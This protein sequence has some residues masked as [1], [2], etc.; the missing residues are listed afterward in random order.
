[1]LRRLLNLGSAVSLVLC[2]AVCVLWAVQASG[3]FW[4][5]RYAPADGRVFGVMAGR[6]AGPGEASCLRL[7]SV[8]PLPHPCLT[9]AF[10]GRGRS[11][12][13]LIM[14]NS[15]YGRWSDTVAVDLYDSEVEMVAVSPAGG[16]R[17]IA[18][19]GTARVWGVSLPYW[20]A[21]VAF[22]LPAVP[23]AGSAWRRHRGRRRRARIGLCPSCG[24]DLRATPG[25]CPECG[26]VAAGAV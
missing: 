9:T 19:L 15:P 25:R 12:T 21:V 7:T 1:M 3:H 5:L 8:S 22:G 4:L 6:R 20:M 17:P 16:E 26:K 18:L 14:L 13:F 10:V 24:Y 11:G 2:A 23:L